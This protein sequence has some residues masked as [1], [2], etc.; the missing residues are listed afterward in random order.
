MEISL[1]L[2]KR[3]LVQNIF[4]ELH[5]N[6][7]KDRYGTACQ[8]RSILA[9]SFVFPDIPENRQP[10]SANLL[11]LPTNFGICYW[12][13]STPFDAKTSRKVIRGHRSWR[14]SARPDSPECWSPEAHKYTHLASYFWPSGT[15]SLTLRCVWP[16]GRGKPST[17]SPKRTT[18]LSGL[19]S[20]FCKPTCTRRVSGTAS[21]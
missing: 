14:S 8:A 16:A 7:L 9:R 19:T 1:R 21:P 12:Q 17:A 4:T 13:N 5:S 6:R 20:A 10:R 18:T 11:P 15:G 2:S 3:L